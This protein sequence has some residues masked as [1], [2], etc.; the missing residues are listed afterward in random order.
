MTAVLFSLTFLLAAPFWALMIFVPRWSWTKRIVESYLIILP[1]VAIYVVLMIPVLPELLPLVTRP[2]LPALAEFMSTD[3]GAAL[4]WA[5][6]I[7]WDLFVGRWMY[8]EGRRL[9]V[10]PLVMA[11][12]LVITILLAPVGLPLFLIVRKVCDTENRG[13][14]VVTRQ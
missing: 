4:V 14:T 12:V 9:N 1:V 5:H 2:E 6:M 11:P 8:L 3:T 7:A 10:H 13:A